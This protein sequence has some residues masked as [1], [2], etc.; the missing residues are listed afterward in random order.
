[1]FA[2]G[3]SYSFKSKL[4]LLL[5][6]FVCTEGAPPPPRRR[7]STHSQLHVTAYS[8]GERFEWMTDMLVHPLD[9]FKSSILIMCTVSDV[10]KLHERGSLSV[11]NSNSVHS[12]FLCTGLQYFFSARMRNGVWLCAFMF[13]S[14]VMSEL[15]GS[16]WTQQQCESRVAE[17]V[18]ALGPHLSG[19]TQQ[20]HLCDWAA[21]WRG[22]GRER[23]R[24]ATAERKGP[25]RT[26]KSRTGEEKKVG[27]INDL[28]ECSPSG[29]PATETEQR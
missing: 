27:W 8:W 14:R 13:K 20:R 9:H 17:V 4:V 22:R 18:A 25:G 21:E 7:C 11:K 2:F 28:F 16:S 29:C 10:A 26:R 1:M 3:L 12:S 5:V 19:N 15:R 24:A 23:D 6:S